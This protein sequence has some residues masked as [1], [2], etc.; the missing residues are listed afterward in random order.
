M[1]WDGQGTVFLL[2]EGQRTHPSRVGSV[3][4]DGNCEVPSRGL[5]SFLARIN[6]V[7]YFFS[8]FPMNP[9][10]NFTRNDRVVLFWESSTPVPSKCLKGCLFSTSIPPP[11]ETLVA[12]HLSLEPLHKNGH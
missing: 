1:A 3:A 2:L 6:A 5:I 10:L 12:T 4:R 9:A 7:I 8:F 11:D